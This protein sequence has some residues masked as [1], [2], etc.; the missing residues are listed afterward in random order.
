MHFHKFIRLYHTLQSDATN[1]NVSAI[2]ESVSKSQ[3]QPQTFFPRSVTVCGMSRSENI[4]NW[5]AGWYSGHNEVGYPSL[6]H[7]R[8]VVAIILRL[9]YGITRGMVPVFEGES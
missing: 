9:F 5:E 6:E 2:L 3:H 4:A 7:P 1:K 8:V